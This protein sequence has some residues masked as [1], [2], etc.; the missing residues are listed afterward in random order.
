MRLLEVKS[1]L[2]MN[3]RLFANLCTANEEVM[4]ECGR[5]KK[6]GL[7][8]EFYLRN[9]FVKVV[10]KDGDFPKKIYHKNK[11]RDLFKDFYDCDNL[12]DN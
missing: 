11:L 9:G 4:R 10:I 2:R 8:H 5:L 6:Y 1:D 12:Y 3:I 7:L